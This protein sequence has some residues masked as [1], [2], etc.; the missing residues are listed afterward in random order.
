[1]SVLAVVS[2]PRR[3][4]RKSRKARTG[5]RHRRAARIH[6]R[7][8]RHA[9]AVNPRK[10]RRSR[11]GAR[12]SRKGFARR[13]R[14]HFGGG[15]SGIMGM[16]KHTLKIGAYAAVG[17]LALD[18]V[19]SYLPLPAA[20]RGGYARHFA[21]AAGAVGLGVLAEKVL[22]RETGKL[23]ALGAMTVV[24]HSALRE[25][26]AQFAPNVQLSSYEDVEALSYLSPGMLQGVGDQYHG[27]GVGEFTTM[28]GR[29]DPMVTGG[30]Y[31]NTANM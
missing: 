30:E 5:R 3:R 28:G 14:G 25:V 31:N 2:N 18:A 1:M 8:R 7:K 11:R 20:V 16:A 22:G 21:K 24:I 29:G 17:A 12:R 27:Y 13:V 10:R 6:R 4:R 19:W 15:G 26:V 9:F 23:F